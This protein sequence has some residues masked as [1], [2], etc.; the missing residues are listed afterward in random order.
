M[1]GVST[2]WACLSSAALCFLLA[3]IG[4]EDRGLLAINIFGGAA[5]LF[6]AFKQLQKDEGNAP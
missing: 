3:A 1:G 4:I 6:L 2:C 5:N